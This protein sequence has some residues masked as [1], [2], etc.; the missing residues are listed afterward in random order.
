MSN[1]EL[2]RVSKR[3]A[4]LLRQV[5]FDWET[6]HFYIESDC[7]ER[8]FPFW[9]KRCSYGSE[10]QNWNAKGDMISAPTISEVLKWFRDVR[11]IQIDFKQKVVLERKK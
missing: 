7:E 9:V 5:G 4:K 1:K 3:Q 11:N 2:Q 6:T 10:M 8:T